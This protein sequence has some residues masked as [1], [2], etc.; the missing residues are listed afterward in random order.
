MSFSPTLP[1]FSL[2]SVQVFRQ[3]SLLVLGR[4]CSPTPSWAIPSTHAPADGWHRHRHPRNE[5]T[6]ASWTSDVCRSSRQ[7]PPE[8]R[9]RSSTAN[10]SRTTLVAATATLL[11]CPTSAVPNAD[12]S[13]R[14]PRLDVARRPF[15]SEHSRAGTQSQARSARILPKGALPCCSE[16]D[17]ANPLTDTTPSHATVLL[18]LSRFAFVVCSTESPRCFARCFV[19]PFKKKESR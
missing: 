9:A 12:C 19:P 11:S 13:W 15:C 16:I 4:G 5:P 6:T 14:R 8:H 10:A 7:L 3:H 17:C 2:L 1:G 18:V